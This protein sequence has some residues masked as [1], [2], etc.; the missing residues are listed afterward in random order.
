M[1][2]I[3]KP[4][5]TGALYLFIATNHYARR[6]NKNRTNYVVNTRYIFK[7]YREFTEI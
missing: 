5:T 3:L 6:Y 2:F 7:E 1:L 4:V